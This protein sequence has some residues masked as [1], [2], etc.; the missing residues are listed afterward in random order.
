MVTKLTRVV[1]AGLILLPALAGAD[2]KID[3]AVAKAFGQIDRNKDILD[4][5][6]KIADKLAKE[7]NA[8]AQLGAA[9]IYAR[10]GKLDLAAG[11]ARKAVELSASATPELRA[12]TLD[13]LAQLELRVA[14]GQDALAHAQEAAKLSP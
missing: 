5:P 4:E 10:T 3:D 1:M 8:E 13:Q 12:Q 9:R 11:A 2:K 7:T 14:S 6:L